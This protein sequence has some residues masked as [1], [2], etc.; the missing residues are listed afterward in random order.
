MASGSSLIP[1]HPDSFDSPA[2]N[3]AVRGIRNTTPH[4]AF[5]DTTDQGAIWSGLILP[6]PN[7]T[8]GGLRVKVHW[9]AATATSGS[10]VWEA[11]LERQ[12]SQD[13]D[14]DGFGA[15]TTASGTA[16]GTSGV[17]TVTN[18]DLTSGTNMDSVAVSE[19]FRLLLRRLPTN[20]SDNMVGNAEV[21]MVEICEL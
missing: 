7:Y 16:N 19:A 2:S 3:S 15:A 1:L 4:I 5:D 10:A 21:T 12:V 18:V 11:S 6:Y 14:S 9:R 13:Q 20:G 17:E 8:G